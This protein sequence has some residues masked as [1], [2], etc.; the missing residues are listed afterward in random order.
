VALFQRRFAQNDASFPLYEEQWSGRASYDYQ[1]KYMLEATL[2]IT[3]SARFAPKNRFGYF[4][5]GAIGWN[6]SKEKF[7][8]KILPV[9]ISNLKARYS[10]GIV[11]FDGVSGYLYISEY[12]NWNIAQ[13]Q[14]SYNAGLYW[15]GFGDIQTL[16]PV[17]REGQVPNINAQWERSTKHNLGFD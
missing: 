6:L 12:T 1:G 9:Q 17:V 13:N 4:P 8:R 16:N 11:G 2:G 15:G 10:Y 5:S 7:I 3:G 14:G